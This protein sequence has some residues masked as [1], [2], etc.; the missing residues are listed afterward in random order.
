MKV[1]AGS[2]V[3]GVELRFDHRGQLW[4]GTNR[5]LEAHGVRY[6]SRCQCVLAVDRFYPTV[7]ICKDCWR[8]DKTRLHGISEWSAK[9]N[10]N[11]TTNRPLAL[12]ALGGRCCMCEKSPE[13]AQKDFG[14]LTMHHPYKRGKL[15][16]SSN[17]E[18]TALLQQSDTT[19]HLRDLLDGKPDARETAIATALDKVAPLC[20][21]CHK[22]VHG[23]TKLG[24]RFVKAEKRIGYQF[25]KE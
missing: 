14:N 23:E 3:Y 24:G 5:K 4:R 8:V 21:A 17:G 1:E 10:K 9:L 15:K 20:Y 2:V 22:R 25:K 7:W 12:M 18:I 11:Y 19:E 6:C 16:K 13:E